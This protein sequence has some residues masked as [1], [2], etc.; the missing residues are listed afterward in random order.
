MVDSASAAVALQ[1]RR[2]A[3]A[4]MLIGLLGWAVATPTIFW[5]QSAHYGYG[6]GFGDG[7]H[8]PTHLT[9][10]ARGSG[11]PDDIVDR[12]RPGMDVDEI[13]QATN[14]RHDGGFWHDAWRLALTFGVLIGAVVFWYQLISRI[15][16][17]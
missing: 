15:G 10:Y 13:A 9:D 14:V 6:S 12:V 17:F 11:V 4:L 3:V 2:V 7:R 8:V 1:S 16:S 5:V